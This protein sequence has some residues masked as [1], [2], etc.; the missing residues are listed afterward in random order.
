MLKSL[1]FYPRRL[2]MTHRSFMEPPSL[3][4]ASLLIPNF[5]SLYSILLLVKPSSSSVTSSSCQTTY[6]CFP[7]SHLNG[8]NSSSDLALPQCWFGGF[9]CMFV[10]VCVFLE[11]GFVVVYVI[12]ISS[13][14]H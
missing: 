5:P 1:N 14:L 8:S 11:L 10:V 4:I 3:S 7:R 12:L 13:E 6:L 9:R 2:A